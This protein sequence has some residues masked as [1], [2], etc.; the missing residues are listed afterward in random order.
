MESWAEAGWGRRTSDSL[1]SSIASTSFL[2]ALEIERGFPAVE[3]RIERRQ[4]RIEAEA[5]G[6]GRCRAFARG[7]GTSI[8][9]SGTFPR[10][11]SELSFAEGTGPWFNGVLV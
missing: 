9:M 11:I 6:E 7:N 5:N 8:R 3:A 1:F 4:Q 2:V 10:I